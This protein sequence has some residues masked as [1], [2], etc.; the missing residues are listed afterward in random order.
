MRYIG[1]FFSEENWLSKSAVILCLNF[2]IHLIKMTKHGALIFKLLNFID[3][4]EKIKAS[5]MQL[6]L[7]PCNFL[8]KE[9]HLSSEE[10]HVIGKNFARCSRRKF[11]RILSPR[12]PFSAGV[13]RRDDV[14][15]QNWRVIARYILSL[16]EPHNEALLLTIARGRSR[17]DAT[18]SHAAKSSPFR[19]ARGT[20]IALLKEYRAL[21]SRRRVK[22]ELGG[23]PKKPELRSA[24]A[25]LT[26]VAPGSEH[27]DI[28]TLENELL[29]WQKCCAVLCEILKES[30]SSVSPYNH[31]K[32]LFRSM[33]RFVR[34]RELF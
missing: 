12:D 13:L 18:V 16:R 4:I 26:A 17:Q 31:L 25:I 23:P 19:E 30:L 15:W 28:T 9:R 22:G 32:G 29:A 3:A 27:I 1:R 34:Q 21:L 20:F 6:S 2:Q 24:A 11:L 14:R 33:Y 5:I 10:I 7:G 8:P